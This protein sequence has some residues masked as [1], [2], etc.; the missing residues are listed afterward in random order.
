MP[1]SS[2]QSCT[3]RPLIW[4]RMYA[5]AS[6]EATIALSVTSRRIRRGATACRRRIVSMRSMMSY[7]RSCTGE[8]FTFTVSSP[9][10]RACHS[11]ICEQTRSST[12]SPIGTMSPVSSAMGMKLDGMTQPRSGCA[13]RSRAS[14]LVVVPSLMRTTGW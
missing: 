13:H 10:P 12:Q 11:S 2:M 1:K 7:W 4:R 5:V 6:G 3:P 8:R 9:V 14:T